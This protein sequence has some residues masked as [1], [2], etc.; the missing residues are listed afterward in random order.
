MAIKR[1]K[2][3]EMGF[4]HLVLRN[5]NPF[6]WFLLHKKFWH[7]NLDSREGE[8]KRRNLG[9]TESKVHFLFFKQ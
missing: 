2:M 4:D 5:A 6:K 9:N 7:R 8:N 1:R 3:A